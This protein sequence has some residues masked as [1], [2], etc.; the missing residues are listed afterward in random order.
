MGGGAPQQPAQTQIPQF[1]STRYRPPRSIK[2]GG[3]QPGPAPAPS[4]FDVFLRPSP[5]QG[6]SRPV[7]LDLLLR[8]LF[9]RPQIEEPMR[10]EPRGGII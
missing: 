9:D 1:G 5:P 2:G 10:P 8:E 3:L 7:S 4:P 6:P